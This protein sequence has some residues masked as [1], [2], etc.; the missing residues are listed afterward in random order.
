VRLPSDA[1]RHA[2]PDDV[3]NTLA[4]RIAWFRELRGMTQDQLAERA[5]ISRMSV[6]DAE[7]GQT[8]MDMRTLVTLAAALETTV[9]VLLGETERNAEAMAADEARR[10]F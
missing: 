7:S 3:A 8:H 1:V 9:G 10:R 6:N 2:W 5:G 4:R